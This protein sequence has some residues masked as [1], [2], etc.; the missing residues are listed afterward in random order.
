MRASLS[1]VAPEQ[2]KELCGELRCTARELAATLEVDHKTVSAW[3][4][5]ELFPTRRLVRQ[6]E[7]LRKQGPDAVVRR[8]RGKKKRVSGMQRLGDPVLWEIL[9]KLLEHPALFEQV[10][11]LADKYDDPASSGQTR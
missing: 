4:E 1:A 5:G 11:K 8:P 2:I 6:M 10:A 3:Q 9:R 7:A